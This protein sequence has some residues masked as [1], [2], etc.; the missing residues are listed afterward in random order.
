LLSSP[1]SNYTQAQGLDNVLT[2]TEKLLVS[3]HRVYLKYDERGALGMLKVAVK[4]LFYVVSA[5]KELA[6]C[7]EYNML[8]SG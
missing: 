6:I 3:D 1:F 7:A 5:V 4:H 2:S 8:F